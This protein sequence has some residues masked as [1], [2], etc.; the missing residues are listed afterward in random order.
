[1]ASTVV[2]DAAP[3][4]KIPVRGQASGIKR[5]MI[6]TRATKMSKFL[7]VWRIEPSSSATRRA[8]QS[9]RMRIVDRSMIAW[10]KCND[11][12]RTRARTATT[13]STSAN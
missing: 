11:E 3:K 7:V 1:V 10:H 9:P 13:H 12:E 6:K 5:V 4:T 2:A 8:M